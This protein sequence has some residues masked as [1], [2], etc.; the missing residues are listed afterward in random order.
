MTRASRYDLVVMTP[1]MPDQTPTAL[2]VA[3]Y[4]LA[5]IAFVVL[6]CVGIRGVI[7]LIRN[8]D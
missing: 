3:D 1:P 2:Y 7:H 8:R 4:V 6:L 5:G